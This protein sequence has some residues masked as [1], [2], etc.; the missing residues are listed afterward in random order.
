[1]RVTFE[2]RFAFEPDF[3]FLN[4]TSVPVLQNHFKKGIFKT[5][6]FAF[7]SKAGKYQPSIVLLKKKQHLKLE[8]DFVVTQYHED[9]LKWFSYTDK[10]SESR[11]FSGYWE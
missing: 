4:S 9:I 7:L 10:F 5:T 11:A 8:H 1:M 2:F 3:C 6:Q